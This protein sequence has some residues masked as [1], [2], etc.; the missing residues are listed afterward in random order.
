M[1]TNKRR[2]R[3]ANG[4]TNEEKAKMTGFTAGKLESIYMS[5]ISVSVPDSRHP[6]DT[7]LISII[8]CH[9]DDDKRYFTIPVNKVDEI[10]DTLQKTR[11]QLLLSQNGVKISPK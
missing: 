11:K 7:L 2:V 8:N 6:A 4:L 3:W 1:S 10:C 9:G 5:G